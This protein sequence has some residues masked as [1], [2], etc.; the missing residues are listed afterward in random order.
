MFFKLIKVHLLVSELYIFTV[1]NTYEYQRRMSDM[2][3]Q[4][5]PIFSKHNIRSLKPTANDKLYKLHITR[6]NNISYFACSGRTHIFPL[7]KN[8]YLISLEVFWHKVLRQTT[9]LLSKLCSFPSAHHQL[10]SSNF[11][12]FFFVSFPTSWIL[13]SFVC[14]MKVF[15]F[16][17]VFSLFTFIVCHRSTLLR[18]APFDMSYCGCRVYGDQYWGSAGQTFH[19]CSY[20][21]IKLCTQ[22]LACSEP[23]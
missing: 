1:L 10:G 16:I 14:T 9:T 15:V 8:I 11:H 7:H 4:K 22:L 13:G 23:A 19:F 18:F 5:C 20:A 3:W 2:L 21:Y 12:F 6:I 17:L